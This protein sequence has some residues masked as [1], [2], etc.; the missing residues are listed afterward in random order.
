MKKRLCSLAL[1]ITVALYAPGSTVASYAAD[2]AP[3][4]EVFAEDAAN[5]DAVYD[6]EELQSASKDCTDFTLLVEFGQT[7]ARTMLDMVNEFRTGSEAWAWNSS[8]TK[9][10][11]LS[12]LSELK[13]DYGLEVVAMVRD[14]AGI[15]LPRTLNISG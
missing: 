4:D 11:Y 7:E 8:D 2:S 9:K 5:W 3:A 15:C 10:V 12:D 13:Y 14:T 1:A 6:A